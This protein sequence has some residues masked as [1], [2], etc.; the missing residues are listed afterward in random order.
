MP[1]VTIP[2]TAKQALIMHKLT[3]NFNASGASSRKKFRD[4][5]LTVW[6]ELKDGCDDMETVRDVII[7]QEMQQGVAE[8]IVAYCNDTSVKDSLKDMAIG[9]AKDCKCSKWVAKQLEK[10]ETPMLESDEAPTS[11]DDDSEG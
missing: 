5:I 4:R 6:P 10:G 1:N 11:D 7:T 3:E 8:G 9:L 2:C